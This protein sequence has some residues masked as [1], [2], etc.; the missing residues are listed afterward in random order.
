MAMD[1]KRGKGGSG[2]VGFSTL[3]TNYGTACVNRRQNG[4]K[5]RERGSPKSEYNPIKA[6]ICVCP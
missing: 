1:D 6:L 3:F 4:S 2:V 5:G